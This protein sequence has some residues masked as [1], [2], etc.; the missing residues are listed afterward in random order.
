MVDSGAVYR[1][2]LEFSDNYASCQN[3]VEW[4]LLINSAGEMILLPLRE[5]VKHSKMGF[6]S[7]ELRGNITLSHKSEQILTS[8]GC[9]IFP[10]LRMIIF[11]VEKRRENRSFFIL[12]EKRFYA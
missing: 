5:S 10:R 3:I 4:K 11:L 12:K 2:V 1:K 8:E 6:G 7:S 9:R